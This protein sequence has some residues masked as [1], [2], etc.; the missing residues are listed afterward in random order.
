M[1]CDDTKLTIL[2]VV[3]KMFP[4]ASDFHPYLY[5]YLS[6]YIYMCVCDCVCVC[7]MD[8]LKLTPIK[9]SDLTS[10]NCIFLT[11]HLGV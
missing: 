6:I 11:V 10:V 7:Q 1:T 4:G 2:G 3:K 9:T 8:S 5:I